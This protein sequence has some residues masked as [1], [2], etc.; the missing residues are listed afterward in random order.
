[1]IPSRDPET[2]RLALRILLWQTAVTLALAALAAPLWGLRVGASA[3]A[4][5]AIGVVAN[6]YMTFAALRP[7][8][9]AALALG[10]MYVGQLVKVLLTVAMFYALARGGWVSW[11]IAIGA[12]I[13]T[14]VVFWV[15]PAASG[16]RLPP[17]SMGNGGPGSREAQG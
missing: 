9:S 6:L 13:A 10:R 2:S 11:P 4:G 15:V 17:R 7:V 8:G 3:L 5:G 1:M 12:Y 14:L 16:P